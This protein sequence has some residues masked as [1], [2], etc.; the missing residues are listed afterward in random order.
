MKFLINILYY[1]TTSAALQLLVSMTP[2]SSFALLLVKVLLIILNS[3]IDELHELITPP[4]AS[5]AFTDNS[6]SNYG[7]VMCTY[8]ASIVNITSSKFTIK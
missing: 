2:P 6:V 5:S 8:Y 1:T 4:L 7:G 3:D